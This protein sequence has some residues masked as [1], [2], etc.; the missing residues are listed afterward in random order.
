MVAGGID[1]IDLIAVLVVDMVLEGGCGFVWLLF[2]DLGQFY[3][4]HVTPNT[5]T[6]SLPQLVVDMGE[7]RESAGR[8]NS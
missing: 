8:G 7:R 6:L 4:T 2:V 1:L 5:K 3:E